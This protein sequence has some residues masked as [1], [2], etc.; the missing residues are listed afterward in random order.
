M[1]DETFY[2]P[3]QQIAELAGS[4]IEGLKPVLEWAAESRPFTIRDNFDQSLRGSQRMLLEDENRMELLS[5]SGVV[6]SQDAAPRERFVADFVDGPVKAALADL[7][8]LRTLLPVVSGNAR[9]GRLALVDNEGKTRARARL[10]MLEPAK[11]NTVVLVT[12]EGLRGYDRALR[13]LVSRIRD[14]DGTSLA[15]GNLYRAID[16]ACVVYD[17]APAIEVGRDETAFDAATDLIDGYLAVARANEAGV[18]E[19]LDTEFLHDYRV[20]LRKVRSVLSLFKSVYDPE[21]TVEL[22]ARFSAVMAPTGQLRDL[23]VQLLDQKRFFDLVPDRMHGGLEAMFSL[24]GGR[25]AEVQ[26]TLARHLRSKIYGRE[27]NALAKLFSRRRNLLPGPNASRASYDFA[28]ELIWKRYRKIGRIAA[29]LTRETPDA[30]VHAL[31]IECKK[32]RYLMEFF[33]PVFPMESFRGILKPLKKLQD[34]LG[35]FN[36]LAIQQTRLLAFSDALGDEP[37]K[38]DIVQSVGALVFVLHQSRAAER[39]RIAAAFAAFNGDK[40]QRT[41]RQLFRAGKEDRCGS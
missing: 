40:T 24:L 5:T 27:I 26:A 15:F 4:D 13:D 10:R 18:I 9:T 31:R 17:S 16:P 36:D 38:F 28:C 21:Q 22:K 14:C 7:S 20:A 8:P 34:S 3:P 39:E 23:D 6:L 19:D 11:G 32:L 37:R 25:R 29:G 33:A 1:L 30:E 35:L 2:M 41:F 12:A